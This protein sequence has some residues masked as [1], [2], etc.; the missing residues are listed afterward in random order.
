MKAM[1]NSSV[2]VVARIEAL[3]QSVAEVRGILIGLFAP[4]RNE[5]GCTTYELWQNKAE[6]TDFTFVE[7]WESEAALDAHAA[8]PHL[9]DATARLEGLIKQAPD[10]RRYD[11]VR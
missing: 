11:L 9:K 5:A 1:P 3:P 7:E 4:T 6:E 2:R 8:S 10:V